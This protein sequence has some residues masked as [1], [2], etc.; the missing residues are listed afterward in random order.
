MSTIHLILSSDSFTLPIPGK[1]AVHGRIGRWTS[2]TAGLS[3]NSGTT[4][5]T[6]D[7]TTRT[8][9]N[10]HSIA[11]EYSRNSISV[12]FTDEGR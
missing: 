11:E 7:I 3:N 4:F 2:S 1:P 10:L 6:S 8:S 12:S 5:G 9:T